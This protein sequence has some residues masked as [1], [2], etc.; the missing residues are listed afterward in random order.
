MGVRIPAVLV[1]DQQLA[2]AR[3]AQ[4]TP[5]MVFVWLPGVFA[6]A[7]VPLP[8]AWPCLDV[9]VGVVVV[10]SLLVLMQSVVGE[11]ERLA[12][13]AVPCVV[14]WVVQGKVQEARVESPH[15]SCRQSPRGLSG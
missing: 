3:S 8:V 4:H 11:V 1:V 12:L 13:P 6:S 15:R 10:S 5:G 7:V 2:P 14:A 9:V